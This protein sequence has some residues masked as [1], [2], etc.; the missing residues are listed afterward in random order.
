MALSILLRLSFNSFSFSIVGQVIGI[1]DETSAKYLS[2]LAFL[3][4]RQDLDENIAAGD[5][6]YN[7]HLSV[8]AAK[9]AYENKA[10]IESTVT[11]HWKVMTTLIFFSSSPFFFLFEVQHPDN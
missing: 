3:D 8:M 11:D 1:P 6:R 5:S 7:P 2:V 9:V 4:L 10:F